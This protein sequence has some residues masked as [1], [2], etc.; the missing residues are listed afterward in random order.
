M[1]S[2]IAMR[3]I[4]LIVILACAGV[5]QAQLPG[6]AVYNTRCAMCHGMPDGRT[7]G[8][9]VLQT[10]TSGRILA[11]LDFGVMMSIAYGMKRD[12]REAVASYLGR[13][14][15]EPPPPARAFCQDR[16]VALANA[17][18]WNGWS[19]SPTNSRFQPAGLSID[20][21]KRLKLKWAFGFEGDTSAFSQP[22]VL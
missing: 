5:I 1:R 22:T 19:P 13:P 12:E 7:P 17:R 4:P 14:G 18:G 9:E 6:E 11:T 2:W 3:H 21:T 8:R 10:L 16:S 20:Q 15:S